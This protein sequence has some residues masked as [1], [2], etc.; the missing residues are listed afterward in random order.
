MLLKF[1]DDPAENA[2]LNM[3]NGAVRTVSEGIE[4][5]LLKVASRFPRCRPSACAQAVD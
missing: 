5:A 3:I 4:A 1:S 2:V